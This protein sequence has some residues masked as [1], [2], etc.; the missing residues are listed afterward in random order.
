MNRLVEYEMLPNLSPI[1]IFV[2][3]PFDGMRMRWGGGPCPEFVDVQGKNAD[4]PPQKYQLSVQTDKQGNTRVLYKHCP[5]S[6]TQ[7][8]E[9]TNDK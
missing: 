8:Q 2:G 3:G 6:P 7:Q 4:K 5:P 1:A 9:K